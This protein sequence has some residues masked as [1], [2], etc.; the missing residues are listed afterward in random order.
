MKSSEVLLSLSG[1]R[2]EVF[3]NK[4]DVCVKY[5]GAEIKNGDFLIDTYGT[6]TNFESA[7]DDYLNKIRGKRL[8]FN[9]YTINRKEIMVLGW[10]NRGWLWQ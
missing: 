1:E 2:L 3:K 7:C 8:V 6:G 4:S 5:N 10:F 9:A